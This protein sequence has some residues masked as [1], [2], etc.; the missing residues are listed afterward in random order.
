[1]VY[2]NIHPRYVIMPWAISKELNSKA[3]ASGKKM[4]VRLWMLVPS[5]SWKIL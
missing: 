2:K 1:M 3:N 5:I 4:D